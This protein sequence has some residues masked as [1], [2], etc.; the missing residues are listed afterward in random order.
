MIPQKTLLTSL[1]IFVIAIAFGALFISKRQN[2]VVPSI[3]PNQ[4]PFKI[5]TGIWTSDDFNKYEPLT[6]PDNVLD[7]SDW[8]TY[9]N[10]EFG[11]EF[12]YPKDWKTVYVKGVCS[13]AGYGVAYV[14]IF[15]QNLPR[16]EAGGTNICIDTNSFNYEDLLLAMNWEE[17][18]KVLTNNISGV[19]FDKKDENDE[20]LNFDIYNLS[21]GKIFYS[22]TDTSKKDTGVLQ[23][24]LLSFRLTK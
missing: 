19:V 4:A 17:K 15:P 16:N 20:W 6:F 7:T 5:E 2:I 12:K 14:S 13:T 9:R 22:F 3:S 11:F 1:I 24:I 18:R 21:N 10:E 23:Q 8:Q